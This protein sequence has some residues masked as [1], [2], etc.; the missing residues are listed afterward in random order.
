LEGSV[1]IETIFGWPGI[2]NYIFSSLFAG[3]MNAVLGGTILVGTVFIFLNT[4]SDL[5]YRLVDP[6]SKAVG[7]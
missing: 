7:A 4:F 5:L 1:L 6:R 3:D 2:G